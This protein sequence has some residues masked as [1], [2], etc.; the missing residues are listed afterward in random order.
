MLLLDDDA[1]AV[2]SEDPT[3]Y[4][5]AY[6]YDYAAASYN[7]GSSRVVHALEAYGQNWNIDHSAELNNLQT[8]INS[9][10]SSVTNLR[11]ELKKAKSASKNTIN[12]NL[13]IAKNNLASLEA[14]YNAKDTGT[15]R[16][17]TIS[18]L[19]KMHTMIQIFNT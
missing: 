6:I 3:D 16:N 12:A 13:S 11:S 7:G 8:Q 9:A 10:Q 17:E 1:A 2:H 14:T 18:Y 15:L 19:Y 4:N 5:P